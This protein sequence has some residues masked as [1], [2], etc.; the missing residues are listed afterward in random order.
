MALLERVK[1]IY[2]KL[3]HCC[4]TSHLIP[5]QLVLGAV[6]HHGYWLRRFSCWA[7]GVKRLN[8]VEVRLEVTLLI[9]A[10]H[11]RDLGGIGH[12]VLLLVQGRLL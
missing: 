4:C 7:S 8:T 1:V 5:L 6:A 11:A 12:Q 3:L 2:H 9:E 10:F